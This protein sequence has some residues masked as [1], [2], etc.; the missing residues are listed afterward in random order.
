MITKLSDMISGYWSSH[1]IICAS[2]KENYSFGLQLMFS[3]SINITI[4]ILISLVLKEPLSWLIYMAAFVPLRMTAGGYH[5]KS[6]FSCISIFCTTYFLLM[7]IEKSVSI[8]H[9]GNLAA[10]IAIIS[11]I[12]VLLVSPVPA[13][14]KPLTPV[15]TQRG[16]MLSVFLVTLFLLSAL[17]L[18]FD[19]ISY[20]AGILQFY[21]GELAAI[22]SLIIAK[23][24]I[25]TAKLSENSVRSHI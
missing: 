22:I 17:L 12:A 13:T 7:M 3:S 23:I 6:H 10:V 8:S 15:Q 11:W 25:A 14:N 5:A 9:V 18:K 1:E 4:V 20:H 24:T 21:L 19:I 2:D 16:Y